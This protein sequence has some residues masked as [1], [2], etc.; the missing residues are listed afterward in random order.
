MEAFA[1]RN[2]CRLTVETS[3]E[4]RFH[5]PEQL[6]AVDRWQRAALADLG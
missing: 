2:G 5:T 6:A 4:H 1:A 3:G